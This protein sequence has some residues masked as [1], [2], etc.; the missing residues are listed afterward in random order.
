LTRNWLNPARAP[1]IA[2]ALLLTAIALATRTRTAP[3]QDSRGFDQII[4]VYATGEERNRQRDLWVFEVHLKPMRM[5]WVDI[6]DPDTGETSRELVW[7]L[8]YKCINRPIATQQDET[9]TQ[10]VNVLD[11]IL[12]PPTFL[13]EFTLVTYDDPETEIPNK[14][15]MDQVIPEAVVEINRVES[16]RPDDVVL[17][18][19]VSI[20]QPVPEPTPEDAT[21]GEWMYGVATWRSVDPETDYFK[22]ILSGFS[23]GYENQPGP[24]GEP[25]RW[26][27]V[28]IQKFT[29]LGDRFDPTQVEFKFDGPARWTYQPADGAA[30]EP[31][32]QPL[33][34]DAGT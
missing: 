2:A 32:V 23:N 33:E 28:A 14:T 5:R 24:G 12:Q 10:P 29:R 9:D 4:K 25:I 6:T 7:Y 31:A 19:T 18:D 26:R 27:K 21:D 1:K 17:S 20:I 11:P 16:H 3:A 13:P 22:V 34:P 30:A 8:A 15:Y